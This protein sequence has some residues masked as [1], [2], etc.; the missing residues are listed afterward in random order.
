MRIRKVLRLAIFSIGLVSCSK[1]S[2]KSA[3]EPKQDVTLT[4]SLGNGV[5]SS[6]SSGPQKY[7]FGTKIQ[8][9]FTAKSGYRNVAA[10]LSGVP[11]NVS[12]TLV[13]DGDK[14]LFAS[15]DSVI[16]LQ[17]EAV[18]ANA[19]ALGFMTSTD[20]ASALKSYQ[21]YLEAIDA[22]YASNPSQ[23]RDLAALA[24]RKAYEATPDSVRE[25]AE[26]LL[27]GRLF[28]PQTSSSPSSNT[29]SLQLSLIHI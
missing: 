6:L 3:T 15:A 17:P 21:T 16:V 24:F 11:A 8:Y 22:L 25:K 18:P 12:G 20:T 27:S 7:A 1:D 13:M 26:G 23:A 10:Q 14:E 2:G 19:S 4:I 29:N 28:G 5:S 9:S